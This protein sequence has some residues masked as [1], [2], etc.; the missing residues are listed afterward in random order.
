MNIQRV[1]AKDGPDEVVTAEVLARAI[2]R[3]RRR[4]AT[5]LHATSVRYVSALQALLIGFADDSA[6]ALPVRNYPEFA[7]LDATEFDQLEIC[8]EGAGLALESRDLHVSIAGLIA[9]S[10]PLLKMAASVVAARNGSRS[11]EAKATASRINGQKG[12][13]PR[14]RTETEPHTE[15]EASAPSLKKTA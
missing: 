7:A 12:G 14:R 4:Q 13:R 10:E 1:R 2:E 5:Q 6:V 15:G 11:S 8:L 9:A 3:G